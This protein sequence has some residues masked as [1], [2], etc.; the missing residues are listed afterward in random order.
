MNEKKNKEELTRYLNNYNLYSTPRKSRRGGGTA[1]LIEKTISV[2][3][4]ELY[5]NDMI[6]FTAITTDRNEIIKSYKE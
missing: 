2:I 1:I 4:E 5:T 3:K 6:E